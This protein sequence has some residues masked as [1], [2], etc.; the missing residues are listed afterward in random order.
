[1]HVVHSR[2]F[3]HQSKENLSNMACRR[4]T[5]SQSSN[6]NIPYR[7]WHVARS[8]PPR[9]QIKSYTVRCLDHIQPQHQGTSLCR[10]KASERS[11]HLASCLESTKK[12]T[13][14]S[15]QASVCKLQSADYSVSVPI[16]DWSCWY[17]IHI[18]RADASDYSLA[19]LKFQGGRSWILATC[20]RLV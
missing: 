1:M 4:F 7:I 2:P 14:R 9:R 6:Q 19:V 10:Q 11:S 18:T 17:T 12:E 5:T 8:Q 15:L 3:H 13:S 16:L 20:T